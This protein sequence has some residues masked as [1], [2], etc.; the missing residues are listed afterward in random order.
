M[1]TIDIEIKSRFIWNLVFDYDN[2]D[3]TGSIVQAYTVKTSGSYT[4]KTYMQSVS[5][6]TQKT[7][8]AHSIDIEAGA[9]YGP[10]S[11]SIKNSNNWS[12]EVSD[13]LTNTTTTQRDET[14]EWSNEEARTYTVG[15][16]SRVCLYQ[17][18]FEADGIYLKES[19]YRSTPEPLKEEEL[20]EEETIITQVRPT[21][22]LKALAVQY[23]GSELDAPKD[24]ITDLNGGSSDIN[25]R[26]AGEFVWLVPKYTT[27][28]KEALTR[29][30]FV[31]QGAHD[32]RYDDL[33]KGAGG[34]YRYLVPVN[35]GSN[36]LIT[37]AA[38]LRSDNSTSKP[39][40]WDAKTY[41]INA[42]RFGFHNASAIDSLLDNEDVSLE[43]ILDE[44]D[45][46]QECKAQNTRLIDYFQRV[47]VLQRLFAYVTGQIE[48]DER[49]RFNDI[50]SIVETCLNEQTQLLVP[51]WETVLD[52][53]PDD[54]KTQMVMASHFSKINAVFLN[55]KPA[56]MFA[57]IRSQPSVIGRLLLHIETPS[58]VDLIIRVIQ[59]D[60]QPTGAGVLEWLSS[61]NLIG[62]LLEL[63]APTHSR[64]IHSVVAE[65]IKNIISMATASPGAGLTEGLQNGRAA[66][67]FA[68][69]LARKEHIETLASYMLI[70]YEPPPLREDGDD[71]ED[72]DDEET[73]EL[74][75]FQSKTSSVVNSVSM[76][77]ELIRK[78]NSDFFE[79]YLFHTLRNRLMQVREHQQMN[80]DGRDEREVLEAA[81]EEMAERMGVVH[82]GPVLEAMM[83]K[84]EALQ[85]YLIHPR[86]LT[87]PLDTTIGSIMP[88]TFERYR[89][90]ELFA[91]LLHCSNMSL[92][93]RTAEQNRMYDSEGRLQ[94]GLAALEELSP[95]VQTN[96]QTDHDAMD[97]SNDEIEPSLELPVT[98][99]HGSLT[100]DS[101]DDMSDD[102]P[103]SSDD[104]AMEEIVMYEEPSHQIELSPISSRTPLPQSPV[105]SLNAAPTPSPPGT[106]PQKGAVSRSPSSGSDPMAGSSPRSRAP[107]RKNS[108][109][110]NHRNSSTTSVEV[111]VGEKLKQRFQQIG[112]LSTLLDM[113]FLYPWNNFLH[114]AVHDVIHQ[115]LTGPVEEGYNRELAIS[116]F[117]D[118]QLMQRIVDG[119]KRNDEEAAKPKGLRLGYMG[120]LMRMSE[121]VLM[122]LER[123]PPDLRLIL[124]EYAPTPGWDDYVMGRY[125]EAKRKDARSL[126]GP[127]PTA[128]AT[129]AKNG[130]RW[131]VDEGDSPLERPAAVTSTSAALNGAPSSTLS[132]PR[133]EFKR[134]GS[135][136][137]VR[138]TA[139]FG[140]PMDQEPEEETSSAPHVHLFARYLAQEMHTSDNTSD[141]EDDDEEGGWLS[142]S[143]FGLAPPPVSAR[144][145]GTNPERRPLPLSTPGFDDAFNPSN[146][147]VHAM[148]EDPFNPNIDDGFGP[149]S[150]AAAI[151]P[152]N[153]ADA[154]FSSSFSDESFDS[155][156]FGD[157]GDFQSA[158]F[159]GD[160]GELTPTTGSWTFA[161]DSSTDDDTG[162][163]ERE[164]ASLSPGVDS[165]RVP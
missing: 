26:F 97:E 86:S 7:A 18:S 125:L 35:D 89:I 118:A 87:G 63:L 94:G 53:S 121:E 105:S 23:T 139:D 52:R 24:R 9:S 11:A 12:K 72:D 134:A 78:N 157:F 158:S 55:K 88:V 42:G 92:L 40:G 15:A 145:P 77:V 33:A 56:E 70:D 110:S 160:S 116:L 14:K 119:Q 71:S 133:G 122:A 140:P 58:F 49:G 148:A 69:E 3:N 21:T 162:S 108:R 37:K 1:S 100:I 4:S 61:E 142:Q 135:A 103:G 98:S 65:L 144:H 67:R 30:D 149:F 126:G 130:P 124:I 141:D 153:G 117:R 156:S 39:S 36:L 8:E 165:A 68:R 96:D 34:N 6:T 84:L 131:K 45:I 159:D 99:P 62:R 59:L 137:P 16:H 95:F 136:R 2:S 115:I 44:D 19:V 60:E 31:N 123:F 29:F 150:D 138:N 93:N 85:N 111:P 76:V 146:A 46:L 154:F 155:E 28:T 50:W 5:E 129:A 32:D 25:N 20:Y 101:D 13:M 120:Y 41:D 161:S 107:S 91:E 109:R 27:N 79:P 66:N 64:D 147:V 48:G 22:Y 47:D 43:A 113:F 112:I 104:D 164:H 128:A 38:L 151:T 51:F 152:A 10:I 163:E 127:R 54:M 80:P 114:A 74:P 90:S 75:N 106:P 82:L 83:P 73:H 81:M 132:E 143:A 17:R 102:E 57:F